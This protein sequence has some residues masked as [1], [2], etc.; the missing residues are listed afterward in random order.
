MTQRRAD[1]DENT[2]AH[3]QT[4]VVTL[5]M[6]TPLTFNW[7]LAESIFAYLGSTLLSF[8]RGGL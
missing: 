1:Q 6:R 2:K 8:L 4:V 7:N 5:L 3:F